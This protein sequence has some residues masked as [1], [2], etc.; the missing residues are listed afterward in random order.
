MNIRIPTPAGFD[1][2]RT[3]YSHGWYD[4]LPFEPAGGGALLRVLD[5]GEGG[6]PFT[7]KVSGADG[8]LKVS[9][10]RRLSKA[11]RARAVRDVRHIFRLD[12]E[13]AEFY[14]A[15]GAHAEFAWIARDGAGRLLRSPTVFEDLVKSICTTNCSWASTKKMVA[16]LVGSLGREAADGRRAFPTPDAMAAE[17][18]EFYRGVVRAGYRAPYLRELAG[19]VASGELRPEEWLSS[20][21]STAELK[22]EMKRVKGVGDYAAENLLKLL[23]RY[24]VLALDSWVRGKFATSRNRGRRCEDAKIARFYSRFGE[25]RGLALWCDMTRDWFD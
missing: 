16:A 14:A 20:A 22:R 1:F 9:A 2:R 8:S 17:P 4:L 7:V 10:P 18:E 11:E 24:D 19:R 23:G 12:D 3:L 6:E 5:A 25:W 13:M 21:L 15:V